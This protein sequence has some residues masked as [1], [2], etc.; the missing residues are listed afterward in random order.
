MSA[1]TPVKNEIVQSYALP[2][3][4]SPGDIKW[5]RMRGPAEVS[6]R[7]LHTIA[8]SGASVLQLQN[9]EASERWNTEVIAFEVN[10]VECEIEFSADTTVLEGLRAL[11]S[12][13]NS[14]TRTAGLP[15]LF[16]CGRDRD[17]RPNAPHE[18]LL[19]ETKSL[20]K[21]ISQYEVVA[22]LNPDEFERQSLRVPTT[23]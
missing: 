5:D 11:V 8:E 1:T 7:I 10:Q 6:K 23:A 14:A 19:I 4:S 17:A 2:G 21:V 13:L 12:E 3:Q 22:G 20:P 16:V 15:L 18:L 9:F